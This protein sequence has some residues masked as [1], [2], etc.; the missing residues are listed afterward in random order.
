M[1]KYFFNWNRLCDL[2]EGE[3]WQWPL[4]SVE[5]FGSSVEC[6]LLFQNM[7]AYISDGTKQHLNEICPFV[8]QAI[9]SRIIVFCLFAFI[10][11]VKYLSKFQPHFNGLQGKLRY[12]II[13]FY[14]TL[15]I[16]FLSLL[17]WKNKLA[18]SQINLN[19]SCNNPQNIFKDK[20]LNMITLDIY[21]KYP[22]YPWNIMQNWFLKTLLWKR[23]FSEYM[24]VTIFEFS[25]LRDLLKGKWGLDL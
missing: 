22:E 19:N 9:E 2:R 4:Q 7:F 10:F 24:S 11:S 3:E 8:I 16:V 14:W 15:K 23:L 6:S 21:G 18:K 5:V 13:M 12:L 20:E 1:K 25:F 17:G